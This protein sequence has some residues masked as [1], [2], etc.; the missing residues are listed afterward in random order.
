MFPNTPWLSGALLLWDRGELTCFL[1][2]DAVTD[3]F[4]LLGFWAGYGMTLLRV[5]GELSII[6]SSDGVADVELSAMGVT[7]YIVIGIA[8]ANTPESTVQLGPGDSPILPAMGD[9]VD[10]GLS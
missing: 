7:A 4:P 2:P 1:G 8:E 5:S 3:T 10:I 9:G 6:S